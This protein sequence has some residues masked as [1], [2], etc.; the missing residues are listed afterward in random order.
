MKTP[1]TLL[2]ILALTLISTSFIYADADGSDYFRIKG[3]ASNDT[4]NVRSKATYRSKKVGEIPPY[5]DCIKNLSC[6]GGLSDADYGN[7]TLS[8]RKAK[9]KKNPQWCKIQYRGIKGW[10][11]GRYLSEGSQSCY[12]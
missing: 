4:L 6:I 11:S 2:N 12:K 10:V 5:A 7:L 1:T 3:V 8:Q 9:L